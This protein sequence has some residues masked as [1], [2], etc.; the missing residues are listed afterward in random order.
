MPR[1]LPA[2]PLEEAQRQQLRQWIA[3]FG[4][5][6]QVALR[7]QIV[8]AAAEGEADNAIAKRLQVSRPTVAVWRT[9][10]A[11]SGPKSL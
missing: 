10:F 4:T 9:R 11:Q 5:P 1:A 8:L 3:A 6:R 7:S 2:L